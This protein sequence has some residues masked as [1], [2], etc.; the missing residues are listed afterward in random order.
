MTNRIKLLF[1]ADG[2]LENP[3]L[4][5]QGLPLLRR[6]SVDKI[7][8]HIISF[9]DAKKAVNEEIAFDLD[10]HGIHWLPIKSLDSASRWQRFQFVFSGLIMALKLCYREQIEVVHCRSYR[11][12]V[13][14]SFIKLFLKRGFVFDMRGFLIDE[15]IMLGRWMPEGLVY[16]LSRL[17]ERWCILSADIVIA[18]TV[19][20]QEMV[21]NQPYFPRET[22]SQKVVIIPNCVDIN[23][24][25]VNPAIR[26]SVREEMKWNNRTVIIFVGEA[27]E[28]EAFDYIISFFLFVKTIHP[29]AYLAFICYGDL[30]K[31]KQIIAQSNI[32]VDDYCLKTVSPKQVP[33][34]LSAADVGILFRRQN[35]F[36]RTV[37][38]PIK[39]AEYLACGLPVV[40]SQGVGDTEQVILDHNVGVVIDTEDPKQISVGANKLVKMIKSDSNLSSRCRE[41]AEKELSLDYAEALYLEAYQ[42]AAAIVKK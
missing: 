2:S 4:H 20:F 40:V 38:S 8:G 18:N 24:F 9:E 30:R 33:D 25:S 31:L 19:G 17:F 11:P 5:S 15:Q 7:I 22:S 16:R 26:A 13:I 29:D 42:K 37:S 39:F 12:A 23:R 3:I 36:I 28:W 34:I 21:I 1:I 27:R 32:S 10:Q 14:G 35:P 41:V 6:L